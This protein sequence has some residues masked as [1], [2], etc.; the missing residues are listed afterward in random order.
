ML[1]R[2][3]DLEDMYLDMLAACK[4]DVLGASQPPGTDACGIAGLEAAL[5]AMDAVSDTVTEEL[6]AAGILAGIEAEAVAG[7]LAQWTAALEPPIRPPALRDGCAATLA[8]AAAEGWH[9]GGARR[10]LKLTRA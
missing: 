6:S 8:A 10:S 4:A 7:V 1:S 2:F 3:R 5:T 9:L